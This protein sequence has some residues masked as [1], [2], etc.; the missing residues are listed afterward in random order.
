ML[1]AT[2]ANGPMVCCPDAAVRL[3][4]RAGGDSMH[5]HVHPHR[6]AWVPIVA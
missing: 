1:G 2:L 3:C 6:V 4:M 5:D